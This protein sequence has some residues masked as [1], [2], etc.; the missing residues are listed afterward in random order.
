MNTWLD[1]EKLR[2]LD[3]PTLRRGGVFLWLHVD[4]PIAI[5]HFEIE[6][7]V[8]EASLAGAKEQ[9]IQGELAK[10]GFE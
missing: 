4:F 7:R 1:G 9:W 5:E 3:A 6:G 2:E 10:M 8:S